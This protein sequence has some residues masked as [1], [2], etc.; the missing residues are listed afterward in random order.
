[1]N[2]SRLFLA[3]ALALSA[4]LPADA[5]P[6]H[7]IK[8]MIGH[9]NL[10]YFEEAAEAFKKTVETESKGDVS[11]EIVTADAEALRLEGRTDAE[12]A[13][14]VGKGEAEMGHSF[15]DVMG[16][17]DP[18][19]M[20]FEAPY[21]FRG[22]RHMEGV[23][24]GPV[25]AE[26]LDGLKSSRIA[27]LAFT[28]SGGANGVATV[29][30]QI[31]APGD[32]KGLK[33]GVFGDKVDHAWLEALGATPVVVRHG[34]NDIVTLADQGKLD[35]VVVTWRNFERGGLDRRFKYFNME[36][37]SYLVSSTYAGD[38]WFK[39]L[40]APLRTLITSAAHQSS[41]IER[42]KTI[43]LNANA[44][45]EM[46]AKGVRQVR[47]TAP[48][49]AAFAAALRPA[50]EQTITPL[51]GAPLV[52]KLRKAPDHRIHPTVPE[53]LASR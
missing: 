28:Y 40:P 35:A 29:D 47:L 4:A 5:A 3:F 18:R 33:V 43:E 53:D 44:K 32:L 41:A 19:L 17:V 27:G 22:Y 14:T 13:A 39:G 49:R 24:E 52:E 10:D 1:M 16:A 50:Y 34:V 37:V 31:R 48:A 36:G 25:G 7:K 8:W 30:R 38:A 20:A 21:L 46:L 2:V 42:A 45:R 15:A 9:V 26:M 11:V 51:L 23:F 12:I 6:K